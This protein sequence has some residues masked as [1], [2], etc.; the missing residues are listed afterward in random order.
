MTVETKPG[1]PGSG[2]D[3]LAA[4]ARRIEEQARRARAASS[5]LAALTGAQKRRALEAAADA[6]EA[7]AERIEAANRLDLEAATENG[8]SRAMVDRLRLDRGGRR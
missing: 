2:T 3:E 5:A 6:L 7:E 1:T 4:L 8:L